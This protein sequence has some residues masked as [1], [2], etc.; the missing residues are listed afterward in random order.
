MSW[1]RKKP[2]VPRLIIPDP[3]AVIPLR[4]AE[5]ELKHDSAGHIHLRRQPELKG[6][7]AKW[8]NWLGHDYS[9]KLELDDWGTLFYGMVNGTHTLRDIADR[10]A[11]Q[12][13]RDRK[14]VEQG[15]ILFTK[16]LLT[17][18]MLQLKVPAE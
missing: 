12:S 10:V 17:L 7:H 4:P 14:D 15:V 5:V 9:R 8:A 16:K 13:Q 6:F 1:F 18:E 3:F 2:P 11:A